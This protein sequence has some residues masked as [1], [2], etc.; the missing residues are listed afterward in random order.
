M[1]DVSRAQTAVQVE[2]DAARAPMPSIARHRVDRFMDVLGRTLEDAD[3]AERLCK[4][5]VRVRIDLKDL[6]GTVVML[7]FAEPPARIA[8]G[9]PE[10]HPDVRLWMWS[11]DLESVLRKRTHLPLQILAGA[12][13]FE[14][15]VRKLLRVLPILTDA[16]MTVAES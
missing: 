9:L 12:V 5:G 8:V 14:G 16:A 2:Q 11:A 15:Y 6:P 1:G 13:E 4:A 10:V 7:L 3:V